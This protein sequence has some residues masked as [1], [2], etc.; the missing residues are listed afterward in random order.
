MFSGIFVTKLSYYRLNIGQLNAFKTKFNSR[1]S[2]DLIY[3][4]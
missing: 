4:R 3:L 2:S 1:L